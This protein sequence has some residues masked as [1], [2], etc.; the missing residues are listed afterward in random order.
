MGWIC[1]LPRPWIIF[2]V[3]FASVICRL[4]GNTLRVEMFCLSSCQL[5]SP[6]GGDEHPFVC[7][8]CMD[9]NKQNKR[10]FAR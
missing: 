7:F 6:R 5:V 4:E 3:V 2:V 1:E 9:V 10:S 8:T